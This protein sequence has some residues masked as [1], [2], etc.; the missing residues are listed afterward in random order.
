MDKKIKCE[1]CAY[2]YYIRRCGEYGFF[3]GCNNNISHFIHFV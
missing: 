2:G 1:R 3:Y